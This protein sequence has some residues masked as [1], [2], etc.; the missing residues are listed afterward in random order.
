MDDFFF[1]FSY[2]RD[3]EDDEALIDEF[4]D[5]LRREVRRRVGL[6]KEDSVAFRDTRNIGIGQE[7]PI[8]LGRALQRS[9]TCVC[10]YSPTYFR[11]PNCGK[12]VQV[13]RVREKLSFSQGRSSTHPA[14]IFPAIWVPCQDEIPQTM[15]DIQFDHGDFP[16]SYRK[17]GLRQLKNVARF[18]DD[19][20]MFIQEFASRIVAAAKE[21]ALLP[22]PETPLLSTI[23]TAFGTL[24]VYAADRLGH[25]PLRKPV[26]LARDERDGEYGT[27]YVTYRF[28]SESLPADVDGLARALIEVSSAEE[29]PTVKPLCHLSL[30]ID[31]SASMN[32]AHK[33]PL[34][35]DAIRELLTNLSPTDFITLIL[36]STR[37][38]L[39]LAAT[40]LGA[41]DI[42]D[43][44]ERIDESGVK[45]GNETLI[46]A[47]LARALREIETTAIEEPGD[48]VNR[49][50]V[51]TDGQ[52]HDLHK[53]T[54][55]GSKLRRY[56][57]EAHAYGFGED[58]SLENLRA[59]VSSI[60]ETGTV[61]AIPDTRN[62][63][64]IFGRISEVTSLISGSEGEL[65]IVFASDV[66]GGDVFRYK[67]GYH[68]FG[69]ELYSSDHI[70]VVPIGVL[71]S[72]RHYCF[73]VE[74]RVMRTQKTLTQFC[75][76]T[77]RYRSG[78]KN[79]ML[80]RQ[81]VL[82]RTMG[83]SV[84][85]SED[86]EVKQ[87]FLILESLRS[88]DP[89]A[90]LESLRARYQLAVLEKRDTSVIEALSKAI[91]EVEKSGSLVNLDTIELDL[92]NADRATVVGHDPTERARW[93]PPPGE[94]Q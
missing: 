73:A 39:V 15:H 21:D 66:I 33:Y 4:Y 86:P 22:L 9:R 40:P 56:K 63:H 12:E 43:V 19:Y 87:A 26:P 1:F 67:P 78:G 88:S 69:R 53:A 62:V 6:I 38:D 94:N 45:F 13:F 30:L 70:V 52:V 36:F 57:I 35:L 41:V 8:E 90:R 64:N 14:A 65:H 77:L 17:F 28:A 37:A 31:V 91:S 11:K 42:D 58:W 92:I 74:G 23:Q 5:D 80:T 75:T 7:W 93:S 84:E 20:K 32:A 24:E 51:L 48:V 59:L 49:L 83:R 50:Y 46:S 2:A 79:C 54:S 76:V 47:A 61:K 34:V 85:A 44:M 55:D 68:Y 16:N 81:M 18:G 3:D 82:P 89:G 72:Q 29:R 60:C 27:F 10:L 25:Q 71:E